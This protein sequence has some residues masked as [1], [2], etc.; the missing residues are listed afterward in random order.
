VSFA[1]AQQIADAVLYE[2]Y[3]LYPYRASSAKNRVRWQFGVLAP[4]TFAERTGSDPWFQQSECL[5][6]PADGQAIDI[7]VRGLQL[8]RRTIEASQEDG[9]FGP[10]AGVSLDGCAVSSWDEGIERSID[11][12]NLDLASLASHDLWH[13]EPIPAER[14]I[15]ELEPDVRIVREQSAVD[16][17]IGVSA[18]RTAGVVRLRLRIENVTPEADVSDEREAALRHSLVGVHALISL[19]GGR[20]ISLLD[21]PDEARETAASCQHHGAWPVLVGAP[22][23]ADLVLCSPIILYDYPSVAPESP[24]DLF[25]GTEI[26]EILSLRIMTLTEEEK[27]EARATD[28][29]ARRIIDRADGLAPG[30]FQRLHGTFRDVAADSPHERAMRDLL[31]PSS[32]PPPEQATIAIG[33]VTIGRGSRVI[34]RPTRRADAIDMFVAGRRARV[35][36]V[37]RDLEGRPFLAVVLDDDPGGDLHAEFGRFLYYGSEEV[38]PVGGIEC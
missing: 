16:L 7:R 32:D 29:R 19:R 6:E 10:V 35:E 13:V 9:A 5:I 15:D 26:D 27:A 23:D 8:Q 34:L 28:D 17:R 20:F 2:G 21:P 30:S 14:Q 22:P 38:E 24:G 1:A 12:P 37:Y 11:L 25:D 33:G 36:G 3:A 31:N 18:E 4:R